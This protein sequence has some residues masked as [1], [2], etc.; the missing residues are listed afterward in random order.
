M[1][2]RLCGVVRIVDLRTHHL[3]WE[4]GEGEAFGYDSQSLES[5]HQW[6]QDRL[7]PE[8]RAT[9]LEKL[10]QLTPTKN[11]QWLVEYRFRR[12]D[13]SYAY[14]YER[15]QRLLQNGNSSRLVASMIDVTHCQWIEAGFRE[16]DETTRLIVDNALDAVISMDAEGIITGWNH[17]S[18]DIFGWTRA[19]AIGERLEA[20][21]VPEQYRAAHRAGLKRLVDTGEAKLL[22]QRI[23]I[24][25]LHKDGHEIPVELSIT[26][27]QSHGKLVFSGFLRDITARKA[28]EKAAKG[29][30]RFPDQNPYPVLRIG[31]DGTILYANPASR[32]VLTAWACQVGSV[33]PSTICHVIG[34]VSVTRANQYLEVEYEQ[35][36]YSLFFVPFHEEE[37]VTVYGKIVLNVSRPSEKCRKLRKQRN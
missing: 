24:T 17:Q 2:A 35:H 37:F 22:K 16:S 19:E 33:A 21:I 1:M 34:D 10:N 5:T 31:F 25:A 4:L 30:T 20:M 11:V 14:I 9:V 27:L 36:T 23:E 3:T 15:G 7:H 18:E 26:P 29:N 13:G 12:A 32:D 8:D 6:W 28:A